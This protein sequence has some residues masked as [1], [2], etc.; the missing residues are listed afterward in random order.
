MSKGV[1]LRDGVG[2]AGTPAFATR[3]WA[4]LAMS[5]GV[6]CIQLDSFGLNLALPQIG[7]DLHAGR[8]SLQWV[9][10]AY[11]LSTGM[12]ML[13]AGRLGDLFGRRRLLA[14]GLAVFGAASLVCALAPS[15]PVL[16]GARVVQGTG[17]AMI[18]PVGLSLLTNVYP[19][20]LRGRATGWALGI[21]GIATACGPFI[22]GA[23]T[24]SVSWRAVFWLNVPLAV[25][26]VVL[27]S[28]TAESYDTNAPR[29]VDWSGL[30]CA[31]AALA[32]LCVV[33]DRGPRWPWPAALAG[34]AVAAALLILFVQRE[35]TATHP[36]VELSLFRNGP[37]VALTLAGAAANTTTVMFLFVVP[38]TLQGQWDLSV[39]LAGTAFLAPALAMA[40]AGPLAG[41]VRPRAALRLMAG[42]LCGGSW[43][44]ACLT[45]T[46]SLTM[47]VVVA[48]VGGAVLGVANSLTLIA[49]Q[50]VIR[51]ERAGEASGVTKTVI[52]VAAGLGV[53]L[54]GSITDHDRGVGSET[55]SDTALLITASGCLAACVVLAVW[56]RRRESQ[57]RAGSGESEG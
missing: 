52:T 10:S 5:V 30:V 4:L 1:T 36:L 35:R 31:T 3:R 54:A 7:R 21:G 46:S 42:C 14:A 26:G 40:L 56:I 37:Y 12:L 50:A 24:E 9:I 29:S 2:G 57:V 22:G 28:H 33:I 49:T 43:V 47:Y 41:R 8:D 6:F 32:A 19:A 38:L 11:L 39:V 25:L 53:G 55:A 45:Q 17:A 48:T 16:V 20:E 15:L 51:P 13:G 27:A 18:M 44:L 34:A 23:L